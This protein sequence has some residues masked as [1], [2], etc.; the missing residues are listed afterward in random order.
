VKTFIKGMVLFVTLNGCYTTMSQRAPQQT[1]HQAPA[2]EASTDY[3]VFYDGLSPYGTWVDNPTYGY[4]WFPNAEPGFSPYATEGHWVYTDDGWMWISDYPWGWAPFHYGRWDLD[5]DYGWFWVPDGEW[6]PAWVSWRRSPGYYGWAPLRPGVRMDDAL[7]RDY[8]EREDRWRFVREGDIYRNDIGRHYIDRS[9]NVT[10]INN[11]TVI[12]NVQNDER[13][14]RRYIAG[15]DRD[16]IQRVTHSPI[17]PVTVR[18][19]DR[20][21]HR[22]NNGELQIY[23]PEVQRTRNGRTPAPPKVVPWNQ[24]KP[25]TDRNAGNRQRDA[26]PADRNRNDQ[27]PT[28]PVVA[29]PV[30]TP[31]DNG[32]RER[33]PTPPV[34]APPVVTPPTTTPPIVTPPANGGRDRRP[35]P[36]VVAPRDNGQRGQPGR[37]RDTAPAVRNRKDLKEKP[38]GANV[39][40]VKEKQVAPPARVRKE[41]PKSKPDEKEKKNREE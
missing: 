29:P 14:H 27:Q 4:V 11:S 38:H 24:A 8:R 35:T 28:L 23:R 12:I 40:S 31:P 15:P 33:R 30:V 36:P 9:N 5:R 41:E 18:D 16:E 22:I 20:P 13:R 39:P 10:I 34:V 6:A 3:Q 1:P 21:G 25:G 32:G 17:E 19:Y 37:S 26:N 7:G 2:Q